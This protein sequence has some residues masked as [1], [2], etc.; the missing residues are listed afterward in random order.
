MSSNAF[1]SRDAG[2]RNVGRR[3]SASAVY[4]LT[5]LNGRYLRHRYVAGYIAR[6]AAAAAQQHPLAGHESG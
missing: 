5:A 2:Q 3:P 4:A 6:S 1:W